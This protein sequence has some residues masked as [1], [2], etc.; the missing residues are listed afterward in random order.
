MSGE[1]SHTRGLA[2]LER[3]NRNSPGVRPTANSPPTAI[4]VANRSVNP[5]TRAMVSAMSATQVAENF[6]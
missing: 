1:G 5:A 4:N 3:S 6:I 2:V